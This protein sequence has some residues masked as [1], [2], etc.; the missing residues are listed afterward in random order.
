MSVTNTSLEVWETELTV[1]LIARK[2]GVDAHLRG[3]LQ[4]VA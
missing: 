3:Q 4:K 2:V 1:E